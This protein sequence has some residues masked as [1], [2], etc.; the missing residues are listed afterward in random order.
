MNSKVQIDNNEI[1]IH[2]TLIFQRICF[3]RLKTNLGCLSLFDNGGMGKMKKSSL[4]DIFV[5]SKVNASLFYCITGSNLPIFVSNMVDIC[6]KNCFFYNKGT[7][8]S[9]ING[10][11]SFKDY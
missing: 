10:I 2:P 3:L 4:Y 5:P 6:V 8:A 7:E 9:Q 11:I 1:V